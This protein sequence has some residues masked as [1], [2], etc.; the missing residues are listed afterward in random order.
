MLIC[1]KSIKGKIMLHEMC[2]LNHRLAWVGRDL[3]DD[4]FPAGGFQLVRWA[5]VARQILS[6]FFLWKSWQETMTKPLRAHHSNFPILGCMEIAV[7]CKTL[8]LVRCGTSL[9]AGRRVS[10][11]TKAF[12]FWVVFQYKLFSINK[13]RLFFWWWT[14]YV[15]HSLLN[16]ATFD[17]KAFYFSI[18]SLYS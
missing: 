9:Q 18:Y 11:C 2:N 13:N 12:K 8:R 7:R 1:V 14:T 4:V 16:S 10:M 3:Q 6:L 5:H 15:N 17:C